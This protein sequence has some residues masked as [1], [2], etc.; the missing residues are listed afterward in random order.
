MKTIKKLKDNI[1]KVAGSALLVGATLTAGAA[2]VSAQ[3]N[4][5]SGD[6]GD[7]PAPFVNEDGEVDT[8]VVVGETAEDG[9]P[10]STAD[11]VSAVE[12][13][14]SLG[15]AAFTEEEV[16]VDVE[17]SGA[18]AGWSAENGITLDRRNSPIFFGQDIDSEENRLDDQD[19]DVLAETTFSSE[20]NEDV[21]VEHDVKVGSES[22]AFDKDVGDVDDPVLHVTNPTSPSVSDETYLMQAE[23]DFSETVDFV[24]AGDGDTEPTAMQMSTSKTEKPSTCSDRT[25]NSQ[26]SPQIQSLYSMDQVKALA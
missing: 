1:G 24:E 19:L 5:S 13:A 7:Y 8:T 21:D 22:Q 4:G 3:D 17:T 26:T 16:N 15:A 20:D 2:A 6:L 10:V 25:S 14:G 12:I 18:V 11:V 9:N 23:V